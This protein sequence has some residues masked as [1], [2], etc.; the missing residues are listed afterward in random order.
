[1]AIDV[2][3]TIENRTAEKYGYGQD[4][5]VRLYLKDTLRGLSEALKMEAQ[6]TGKKI[7]DVA[8]GNS[9]PEDPTTVATRRFLNGLFTPR[10]VA[11]QREA[12]TQL[13]LKLHQPWVC[14]LLAQCGAEVTGV[15]LS[16]PRYS[17]EPQVEPDWHFEQRDL[18]QSGS[19]NPQSFPTRHYDFVLCNRFIGPDALAAP[20]LMTL[21][22]HSPKSYEAVER[23]LLQ[24]LT[25]VLKQEGTFLWNGKAYRPKGRK[26][27]PLQ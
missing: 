20:E 14:R 16:Y 7:L 10:E 26:F 27:L 12:I 3:D 4:I 13:A 22:D 23:S 21:R 18:T 6:W 2:P 1:M 24:Q 15:D 5:Q 11:E 17:P 9:A 19:I 25:R 8:C